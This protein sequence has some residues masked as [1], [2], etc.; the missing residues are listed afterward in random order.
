MAKKTTAGD[1]KKA[2]GYVRVST[3]GQA[4]GL[5][6]QRAALAEWAR[7]EGVE[8]VAVHE[9]RVS[10]GAHVGDRPGLIGALED[11][12][13]K[14]AGVL[15]VHKADRLARSTLVAAVAEAS[16]H[17]AGAVVQAA[18]GVGNGTGPEAALLR[19]IV[20]AVAEFERAQIRG[21]VVR[22]MAIKRSRGENL[23]TAPLGSR[24]ADD[25]VRLEVHDGERR[26]MLRAR[27]LRAEGRSLRSVGAA[28]AAEGF[29]GRTGKPLVP[30]S[31][32]ALLA[33]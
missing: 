14:G 20:A 19:Q 4:L 24:V 12:R 16:V 27:A 29:H 6:V 28:L 5:E 15:V 13:A 7:R 25:G 10:G 2:I 22:A 18:D 31:V 8:L 26:A 32:R 30:T 23:G 11:L 21:R 1:P 17:A 9:D 3:E 33:D